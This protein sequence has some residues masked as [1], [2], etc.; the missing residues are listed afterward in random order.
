MFDFAF[1]NK[2][3]DSKHDCDTKATTASISLLQ[4]YSTED[5]SK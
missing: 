2:S 5:Y 1:S 4:I 3:P